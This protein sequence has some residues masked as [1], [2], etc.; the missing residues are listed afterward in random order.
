LGVPLA[1]KRS[2]VGLS[3]ISFCPTAQILRC[4]KDAG[5]IPNVPTAILSAQPA[6]T[7]IPPLP[8]RRTPKIKNGR[9]FQ[10]RRFS[11]FNYQF[12]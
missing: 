4:K 1:R 11:K 8:A 7:K 2:R 5:S 3:P 6:R 9:L 12:T 10:I